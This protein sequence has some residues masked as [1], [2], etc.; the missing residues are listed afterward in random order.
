MS[1]RPSSQMAQMQ[2][3]MQMQLQQQQTQ[4]A[5][6]LAQE[7]ANFQAQQAQQKAAAAAKVAA[8]QAAMDANIKKATQR[9][10]K[11]GTLLTSPTGLLGNPILSGTKLSA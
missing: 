2:Q 8:D 4:S 1:K 6:A 11:L 7:Q 10:V 3:I 9:P 5:N